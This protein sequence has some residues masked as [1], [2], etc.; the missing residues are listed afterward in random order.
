MGEFHEPERI[1]MNKQEFLSM[2]DHTILKADATKD[3]V[4]KILEFAKANHT[5]SV[6]INP[7]YVK[8]ASEYLKG[9]GVKVCTV[10]GFPLGQ[11]TKEVKVF[12]TK[13]AIKNGAEEID[14]VINVPALKDKNYDFVKSEIK[15]IYDAVK[16]S[17]KLLKVIIE[18]AYL[19]DEEKV[20]VCE[21]CKEVG[22]DFV[23]TSTGFAPTG[24]TAS[25]VK[26]MKA[27]VGDKCKI[28]A[29]G[30]IKNKADVDA[31]YEAGATR[32]GVSRTEEILK[33]F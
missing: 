2:A 31:L 22:V 12:E 11:N 17:N 21:I 7:Y 19:T 25:D 33:E 9:S 27:T 13:D 20:K 5:A 4:D 14:M 15:E 26:I 28:K 32:F 8:Y 24:A 1:A 23:K 6:C 3:K 10:I 30:G 18:N 29:A 16:E